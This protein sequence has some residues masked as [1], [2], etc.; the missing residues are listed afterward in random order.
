MRFS[1][2]WTLLWTKSISP[3]NY[4]VIINVDTPERMFYI[5]IKRKSIHVK[6]I[7]NFY[8]KK[9]ERKI[10]E[11]NSVLIEAFAFLHKMIKIS[12]IYGL[13]QD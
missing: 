11:A 1:K 8:F 5:I 9:S 4:E 6:P 13:I 7:S 10:D 12:T 3:V 2:S